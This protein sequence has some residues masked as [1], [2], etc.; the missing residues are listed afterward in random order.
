MELLGIA[1]F[2]PLATR[3][4]L[5][6]QLAHPPAWVW[7]RSPAKS[8]NLDGVTISAGES[9]IFQNLDGVPLAEM[10]PK[11]GPTK[12]K[13][14]LD[15]VPNLRMGPVKFFHVP[16]GVPDFSDGTRK[17]NSRCA[18]SESHSPDGTRDFS[19]AD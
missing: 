2:R 19:A 11:H 4:H 16:V 13:L 15:G 5:F 3:C 1:T 9:I 10:V 8:V 18:C 17:K 12:K 7:I 14:N 6:Q